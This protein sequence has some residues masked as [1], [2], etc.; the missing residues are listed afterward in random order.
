MPNVNAN[1]FEQDGPTNYEKWNYIVG[2]AHA[3]MI[4]GMSQDIA[5]IKE[6]LKLHNDA[7][8]AASAAVLDMPQVKQSEKPS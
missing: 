3:Q 7:H 1:P 6:E 4:I 5:R 8:R 2:Q